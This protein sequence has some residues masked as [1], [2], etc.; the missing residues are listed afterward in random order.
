MVNWWQVKQVKRWKADCCTLWAEQCTLTE[1]LLYLNQILVLTLEGLHMKHSL[2]NVM[3]VFA[4]RPKE[5]AEHFDRLGVKKERE[6]GGGRRFPM[7]EFC[8]REG[9]T[10]RSEKGEGNLLCAEKT[11]WLAS[12]FMIGINFYIN[13]GRVVLQCKFD[14]ILEGCICSLQCN[15]E[16]E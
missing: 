9:K 16:F 11:S 3:W 8:L 6:G 5:K 13:V 15:V 14:N 7:E 1:F 10:L 4:L 2:Q 12:L